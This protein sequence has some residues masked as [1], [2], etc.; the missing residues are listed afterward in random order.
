METKKLIEELISLPVEERA[1]I[2]DSILKTLNPIDNNIEKKWMKV[3][4]DRLKELKSG[5]VQAIPGDE[6]FN[7]IWKRYSL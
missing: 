3:A 1:I 6:V 4:N 7:K 5:N 2:A